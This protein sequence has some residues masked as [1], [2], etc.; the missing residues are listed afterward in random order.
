M[1][2]LGGVVIARQIALGVDYAYFVPPPEFRGGQDLELVRPLRQVVRQLGGQ[3]R[4]VAVVEPM[5]GDQPRQEGAVHPASDVVTGRNR[6]EG[7]GVVVE[8][9]RVVK[10]GGFGGLL[11]EAAHAFGAVVEPPGGA[12]LQRR[13]VAGQRREL[14]AVGR[15]VQSK[16]NDREP[17]DR[18]S[19][20]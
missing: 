20:V 1:S 16:E 17:L 14:A 10:A 12:E 7:P 18:K 9:D 15:L 6:Q 5:L 8:S 13:I 3:F 4:S 19:V 11:A 2:A